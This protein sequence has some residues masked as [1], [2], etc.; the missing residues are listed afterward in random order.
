MP[1]KDA[2]FPGKSHGS[3]GGASLDRVIHEANKAANDAID[4]HVEQNDPHPD[5]TTEAEV[6]TLVTP[7]LP[8]LPR[9]VTYWKWS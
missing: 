5:Y 8:T 4:D 2:G 3:V 6:T 7:M 9:F 1:N